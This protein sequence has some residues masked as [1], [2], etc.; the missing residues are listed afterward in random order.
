[1]SIQKKSLIRA[2]K[3]TKKAKGSSGPVGT[4]TS[5]MAMK[6]V[7]LT[8]RGVKLLSAKKKEMFKKPF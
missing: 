8:E 4:K 3:T 2:M 6:K 7:H 1:M 5:S